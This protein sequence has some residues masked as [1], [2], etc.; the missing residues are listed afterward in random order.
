MVK[1]VVGS[2]YAHKSNVTELL[3]NIKDRDWAVTVAVCIAEYK[4]PF[5]VVKYDTRKQTLSFI[6]SPDWDY[7]NE[8]IVGDSAVF[9]LKK[10]VHL[11]NLE[12][13][14]VKQ[15]KNPKIYHNKWQFVANDYLGFDI[16]AAKRRTDLWNRVKELR[17]NKARIGN[18]DYWYAMLDKYGLSR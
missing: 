9:Y 2:I 10:G 1:K 16:E 15:C 11:C 3:Q 18:R 12:T 4:Q 6:L 14:V 8:P 7:A 13:R 17:E 5:D